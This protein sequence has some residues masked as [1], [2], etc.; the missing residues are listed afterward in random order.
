M[1]LVLL[2]IRKPHL[3][4]AQNRKQLLKGNLLEKNRSIK[5]LLIFL[6][7]TFIGLANFNRFTTNELAEGQSPPVQ[8]LFVNEMTGAYA[9]LVILPFLLWSFRKFPLK[10]KNLPK[11]LPLYLLA[12]M[13]FGASHTM[14]MFL[15]R[16]A[17]YWLVLQES[18]NYGHL[19]LRFVMEY[20]HQIFTFWLIYGVVFVATAIRENQKQKLK[21]SQ[22]EEQLSK[23]RL[24]ALQM[25]LNPHFLFN[26]LNMISSTMYEDVDA[27]DKMLT[28]LSD[29]LRVTLNRTNA[30][31]H[32]LEK[33]IEHVNLYIDIMKAR[34]NEK[35]HIK[36]NIEDDANYALVPGLILQPLVENAIVYSMKSVDTAEIE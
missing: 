21:A 18:Y 1:S 22:L 9:I 25:Q 27:A 14:L 19:G 4:M 15:S 17:I 33:E 23:A 10:R 7:C 30:Q 32:S 2:I 12:S 3:T 35:L 28:R 26:T 11:R 5:W 29:L 16:K 24:Q 6:F 20:N 31:Q 36:M 13:I 34:F 8:K